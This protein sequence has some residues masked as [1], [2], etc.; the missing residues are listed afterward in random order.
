MRRL[1]FC[2]ILAFGALALSSHVSV[3]QDTSAEDLVK[4]LGSDDWKVRE[5]AERKL[6]GMG[7][8]AREALTDGLTDDDLE[9]Q[10][11]ASE[12][13]IEIGETF[14]HSVQCAKS[15][16]KAL[17]RHGMNALFDLFELDNPRV[18]RPLTPNELSNNNYGY[19]NRRAEPFNHAPELFFA[20]LQ[21]KSGYPILFHSSVTDRRKKLFERK[22]INI[23]F[24]GDLDKINILRNGLLQINGQ[25]LGTNK[26][27]EMIYFVPFKSGRLNFVVGVA[28]TGKDVLTRKV[29]EQLLTDLLSDDSV[30]SVRSARI[31][32]N[33]AQSDPKTSRA[34]RDE[35]LKDSTQQPLAW[36]SLWLFPKNAKVQSA[37]K[38]NFPDAA[39]D[40]FGENDVTAFA[41]ARLYLA[42]HT[43]AEQAS[44]LSRVIATEQR[45]IPLTYALWLARDH[46]LTAE[47][48]TR[49]ATLL[50]SRS[51]TLATTAMRW[52][53][54][55]QSITDTELDRLWLTA[56]K[57]KGAGTFLGAALKFV[58]RKDL[59]GRLADRAR[60]T[61]GQDTFY[62]DQVAMAVT[63]LKN[64]STLEDLS[65][66]IKNLTKATSRPEIAT[67]IFD[68]FQ[69]VQSLP[70]DT[71]KTVIANLASSDPKKRAPFLSLLRRMAP[72]LIVSIGKD[73]LAEIE[74]TQPAVYDAV[75]PPKEPEGEEP[76]EEPEPNDPSAPEPPKKT[77]VKHP[78]LEV[79]R[80]ELHG[81]M[82]R[83]GNQDSLTYI[84]RATESEN[85]ELAKSA[86]R[87]LVDALE[88]DSAVKSLTTLGAN[89]AVPQLVE[90]K[91]AAYRRMAQRAIESLNRKQFR[92]A[93]SNAT[94]LRHNNSWQIRNEFNQLSNELSSRIKNQ[95][96]DSDLPTDL[97]LAGLSVTDT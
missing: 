20:R 44:F 39:A 15:D 25:V 2:L 64:Q 49:V 71:R 26:P 18:F 33:A 75:R 6:I 97:D 40:W 17:Q 7:E 37:V 8:K 80:I 51:E 3:A 19:Y 10:T 28:K 22:V 30:A 79:A 63:V 91:L 14:A 68:M 9:V 57:R 83:A 13:L 23:Q 88:F 45:T 1:A 31:L 96:S 36:A 65:N 5:R 93:K 4:R 43:D 38:A 95:E 58:A 27:N 47:A 77:K 56:E 70:D 48:R 76:A 41:F 90:V 92:I 60:K 84:T 24:Q 81:V 89:G 29:G 50:D 85:L 73:V 62:G 42:C 78:P 59:A 16:D 12:A 66:A 82:A 55:A 52:Y 46:A 34:L 53:V 86:G 69:N 21:V 54:T 35:F 74:R 87:A 67:A 32:A 94:R 72:K 61:L 11:R